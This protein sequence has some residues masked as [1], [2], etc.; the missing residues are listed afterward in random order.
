MRIQC[1]SG[2]IIRMEEILHSNENPIYVFPEGIAQP[3]FQFP[4]SCVDIFPGSVHI[5]SCSK[6][7][8]RIVG[9]YIS[10]TDT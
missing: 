9:I 10:L 6:I 7:G 5:F 3:Q 4:H 8:R 1:L 2:R